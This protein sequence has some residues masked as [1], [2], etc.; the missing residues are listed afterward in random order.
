VTQTIHSTRFGALTYEEEAVI[1]FPDGL[2]GFDDALRFVAVPQGED[3]PFVWLQS[4]ERED[5]AFL[6]LAPAAVFPDY[7]PGVGEDAPGVT[8]WVIATIP[9]GRPREMTANLLGPLVIDEPARVGRQVVLEADR[10]NTR[11]AVFSAEPAAAA[12][13]ATAA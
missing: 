10:Y 4:L 9:P 7:R 8:L 13:A 6:L 5:L 11:H 1:R 2:P 3:S 12:A